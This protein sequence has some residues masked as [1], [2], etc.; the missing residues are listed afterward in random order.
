MTIRTQYFGEIRVVYSEDG[1]RDTML[2][3]DNI[4]DGEGNM[5][6]IRQTNSGKMVA[7]AIY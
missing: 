3:Y 1:L 6:E 5:Y 4:S 2:S 7:L